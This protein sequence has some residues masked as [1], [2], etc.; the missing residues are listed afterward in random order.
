MHLPRLIAH[1]VASCGLPALSSSVSGQLAP[2][3]PG[4]EG[5]CV[6]L[7]SSQGSALSILVLCA[8]PAAPWAGPWPRSQAVGTAPFTP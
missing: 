5:R 2:Q 6:D 1:F 7:L 4:G 3:T 8:V